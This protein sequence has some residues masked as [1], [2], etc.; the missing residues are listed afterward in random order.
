M[1]STS[2]HLLTTLPFSIRGEHLMGQ[3]MFKVM[4]RAQSLERQGHYVYHLELGNPRMPPPGAIIDATIGAIHDKQLGYTPMAGL[5][6]LRAAV[7]KRYARFTGRQVR[8]DHVVISPANLLISQ[9]LDLTCDTGDSVVVFMPAFPSYWAAI[10]HI[11]LHATA[12][13][14]NQE[15]GFHL[16]ERHIDAAMSARPKAIIVNSANNPTGAVYTQP[17]LELLAH[18]CEEERVWLLSDETYGDLS[19]GWPFFSLAAIDSSQIVTMS[20]F[21][22]I[23]SIP[24]FRVGYAIAHPSV[25]EKLALSCSTLISCLPAFTQL[26]CVA[27]LSVLEDYVGRVRQHCVRMTRQCVD[28]VNASGAVRCGTPESGFYLFLDITEIGIDDVAFCQRLLEERHTAVTPG[29]S[30]GEA[31][32]S[33]VRVAMCGEETD[34]LEGLHRVLDLAVELKGTH[35]AR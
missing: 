12:I 28:L 32:R 22:K 25:S 34:V 23:F 21:S 11:G 6:E 15:T 20:S 31:C 7:A 16:T 17:M 8:Q 19:F 13:P 30:F 14:L 24:G 4:E 9:F 1:A 29:R 26:G 27:G 10:E 2:T 5:P 35:G 33:F 3:E 18:R